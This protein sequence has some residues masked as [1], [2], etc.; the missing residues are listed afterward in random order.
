MCCGVQMYI[1]IEIRVCCVGGVYGG[2]WSV[3]RCSL[4]SRGKTKG[5]RKPRRKRDWKNN[6][7]FCFLGR[8]VLSDNGPSAGV[9]IGV[10]GERQRDTCTDV[11][12]G[13]SDGEG[14]GLLAV[15]TAIQS[16]GRALYLYALP[17]STL[18]V[19]VYLRISGRADTV[20]SR[21]GCVCIVVWWAKNSIEVSRH[22]ML[23]D[24]CL[25]KQEV[26]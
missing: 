17:I 2:C 16:R 14:W 15:R 22:R 10:H 23:K 12:P 18:A 1:H 21:E 8:I 3:L 25:K 7:C 4:G 24:G 20:D 19:S 26:S 5:E 9:L 11:H 13:E 6:L